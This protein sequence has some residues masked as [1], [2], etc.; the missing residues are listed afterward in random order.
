MCS[1]DLVDRDHLEGLAVR[2]QEGIVA[3]HALDQ[4]SRA[5]YPVGVG[6]TSNFTSVQ[7][8]IAGKAAAGYA[9]DI[10]ASEISPEKLA[11]L[12]A[13][14]E[15]PLGITEGF[16]PDWARDQLHAIMAPYWITAAK[17]ESTLQG[18]LEQVLYMR[19]NVIFCR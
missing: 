19:D 1:S 2:Q 3:E 13:D 10:A 7:G 14:I 8:D 11:E 15:A 16:S 12:V 17:N 9:A 6:F 4:L 5:M 18:A